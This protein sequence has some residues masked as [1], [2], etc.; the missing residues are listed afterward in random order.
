[1][2]SFGVV[3][4]EILMGKH[5]KEVLSSLSSSSTK[6]VMLVEVLDKRL[7]PPKCK[8]DVENVLLVSTIAFA[9][10]DANPKR[11]PTMESVS[12][13]LLSCTAPLLADHCFHEISIGH[14]MNIPQDA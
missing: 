9:C 4:L 5:P 13:Q 3:A 14:L 6:S 2:Y 7:A 10:L 8:L 1:M 12:Q 11:R